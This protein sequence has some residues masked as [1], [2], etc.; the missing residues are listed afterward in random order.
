M[1]SVVRQPGALFIHPDQ[2]F[3]LV[4]LWEKTS[5]QN[6]NERTPESQKFIKRK[7]T[8]F[9]RKLQVTENEHM[10][11]S[12]PTFFDR[13]SSYFHVWYSSVGTRLLSRVPNLIFRVT[14]CHGVQ[15]QHPN[16]RQRKRCK[17]R[18]LGVRPQNE[19]ELALKSQKLG[20][21]KRTGP[22]K[23]VN[24]F[25][26]RDGPVIPTVTATSEGAKKERRA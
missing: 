25:S 23:L 4:H 13:V 2:A 16:S 17:S 5:Q 3:K 19:N 1:S 22:G 8:Q 12:G 18:K 21:R 24:Q 6:E 10:F 11:A 15:G 14:C 7:R 9:P 26:L 20:K